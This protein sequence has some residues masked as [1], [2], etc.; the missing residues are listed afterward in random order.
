M[1]KEIVVDEVDSDEKRGAA[2]NGDTENY[3]KDEEKELHKSEPSPQP[4]PPTFR[5]LLQIIRPTETL[6]GAGTKVLRSIGSSKLR[7]LD[8]FLVLDE[9]FAKKPAGFTDHPQRG[10]ETVSYMLEGTLMHEDC[11]GY[12]SS[13]APGG[14]MW[15]TAG[16][17]IVHAEAPA[18]DGIN[19]AIQLWI[20]LP[21]AHKMVAPRYQEKADNDI[22]RATSSDGKVSVKVIAG[23]SLGAKARVI[24]Y[25]PI[26]YLDVRLDPGARF[27]QTIPDGYTT[28]VYV[29][30]G[31]IKVGGA[32]VVER[33]Q[34]GILGN[35]GSHSLIEAEQ[36]A[37]L[38]LVAGEPINEPIIQ[39]GPF[40]MNT[41]QEVMQAMIDYQACING[42]EQAADFESELTRTNVVA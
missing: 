25:T 34:L 5:S 20:N 24:T 13:V 36:N 37:R 31:K 6:E 32:G 23:E 39:H 15:M 30:E 33:H 3:A 17:G 38:L 11:A 16:K 29:L 27:E 14:V 9:T 21:K 19:H 26:M 8:P 1:E 10:F 40:V 7:N 12:K 28:I 2:E 4:Q 42:F 41:Y 22:P 18:D 35:D